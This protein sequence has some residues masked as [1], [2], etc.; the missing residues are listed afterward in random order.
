MLTHTDHSTILTVHSAAVNS[1]T[2]ELLN[3]LFSGIL[4]LALP[5]NSVIS[6]LIPPVTSNSPDGAA[7][8]SN[9][10][11]ITPSTSAPSA[12]FISL[13]L[14]RPGSDTVPA[15]L[16]IGRHPSYVTEP[17]RVQ[18]T[19]PLSEHVGALFWKAPVKAITVWAEGIELPVQLGQSNTGA[20]YPSALL[21]SGTPLIFTTRAVANGIYGAI[22]ISAATDGQYY[23]PCTRPLNMT[24][25]L[26][27]FEPIA[28][29]P[30]DLTTSDNNKCIGLIQS[31]D[32][33]LTGS[34]APADIIL[35][36]PFLR[37][38]YT[39]MAYEP[40]DSSGT[41]NYS[42]SSSSPKDIQPRLGL[43]GIT[44]PTKALD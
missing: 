14:S 5:L 43:L 20:Q 19:E 24:I 2:S 6:S 36:V 34:S 32:A 23:V 44:D 22:G 9:L 26:D 33:A 1:V 41:F 15:Q 35:G 12:R 18:Y 39:V 10:F 8:A 13:L 21:D 11:S 27:G 16:A 17:G 7:W 28:L 3:P 30:L 38:V 25:T 29:H 4:G 31:A 37:N 40:P 42:S